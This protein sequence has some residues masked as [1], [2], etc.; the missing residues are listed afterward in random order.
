MADLSVEK[1][2]CIGSPERADEGSDREPHKGEFNPHGCKSLEA[3]AGECG[4]DPLF[5]FGEAEQILC[6]LRQ[7]SPG[8]T[9]PVLTPWQN[10]A[11][12]SDDNGRVFADQYGN[13]IHIPL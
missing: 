8:W 6:L 3:G 9:L 11:L 1:M 12:L 2:R 5:S 7:M 13:V 4:Y 10:Y